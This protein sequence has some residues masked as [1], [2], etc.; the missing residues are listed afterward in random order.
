ML[1]ED[2]PRGRKLRAHKLK[3]SGKKGE[4]RAKQ[5]SMMKGSVTEGKRIRAKRIPKK[6]RERYNV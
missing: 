1:R 2:S 4:E 3:E 6:V 5:M